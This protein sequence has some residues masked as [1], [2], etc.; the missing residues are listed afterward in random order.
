[1]R[2][3]LPSRSSADRMTSKFAVGVHL[4]FVDQ[5]LAV[6]AIPFIVCSPTYRAVPRL[7]KSR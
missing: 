4:E 1:M 5:A 7:P 3:Q 6:D 2:I